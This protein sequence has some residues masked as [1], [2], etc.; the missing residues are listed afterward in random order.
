VTTPDFDRAFIRANKMA[1]DIAAR[2][3]A[4]SP[5]RTFVGRVGT[6]YPT[7]TAL[8]LRA[9][10]AAAR[11]A[12]RATLDVEALRRLVGP[13]LLLVDSAATTPAEYLRRPDLGRRL[14]TG[15]RDFVR[16]RAEAHAD[17][18]IVVGDGLSATAVTEQLPRLLPSLLAGLAQDGWG[19]GRIVAVT[20]CRVGI[21]NEIGE[22][23]APKAIVLLIGERPGL[24]NAASLS[25]YLGWR[26][27]ASQTD[28]DRNLVSNIHDR[29]VPIDAATTRIL[30]LLAAMRAEDG[31]GF[32]VKETLPVSAT[33]PLGEQPSASTTR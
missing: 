26:P 19:V 5:A 2:A 29:G 1:D 9:D 28:A 7:A 4:I 25:A 31:G 11:D 30:G 14:S 27:N 21:M 32:A 20:R 33:P 6:A 8:R 10:H 24:A 18:Q 3:A 17:V 23:L 15:G 22:L 13:D 16:A 12:V